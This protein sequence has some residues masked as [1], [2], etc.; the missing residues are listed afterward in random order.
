MS[1]VE[2]LLAKAKVCVS[3]TTSGRPRF[4]TK[5]LQALARGVYS[6]TRLHACFHLHALGR[7]G[8]ICVPIYLSI[9][10]ASPT[11]PHARWHVC[12]RTHA[13]SS[14]QVPVVTTEKG[15]LGY[16]IPLNTSTAQPHR[17]C[18]SE[19][20]G[21]CRQFLRLCLSCYV[22]VRVRVRVLFRLTHIVDAC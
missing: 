5:H 17:S 11:R 12:A 1:D 8:C 22:D 19:A 21:R 4:Q 6:L 9:C 3:P 10:S 20:N 7:K 14:I 2:A 15:S 16:H 13:L 18:Q